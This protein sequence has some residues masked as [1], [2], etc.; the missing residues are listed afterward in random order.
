VVVNGYRQLLFRRFLSD[1]V[2]IEKGFHFLRL[3]KL[4]GTLRG[5]SGRAVIF[6]NGIADCY[7][8]VTNVSSRI[9]AG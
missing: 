9:I 5:R 6:Q 2:L 8:L 4:I 3:G 7:A 1:Y